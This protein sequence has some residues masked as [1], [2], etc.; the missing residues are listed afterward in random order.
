[1][2]YAWDWGDGSS[3]GS[4]VEAEHAYAVAGSYEVVLT[5]TD[6]LGATSTVTKTV[7]VST[8]PPMLRGKR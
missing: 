2:S 6:S 8:T 3:A 4:G 7:E 5:V 1:M